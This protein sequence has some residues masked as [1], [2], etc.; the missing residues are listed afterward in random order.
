MFSYRIFYLIMRGGKH[1]VGTIESGDGFRS[2]CRS[3]KI[4]PVTLAVEW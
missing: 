3:I 1:K 2:C 4:C